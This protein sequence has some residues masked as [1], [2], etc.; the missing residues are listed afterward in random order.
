[1][2]ASVNHIFDVRLSIALWILAA[3]AHKNGNVATRKN[4]TMAETNPPYI[5]MTDGRFPW[6]IYK[7]IKKVDPLNIYIYIIQR[8]S[9]RSAF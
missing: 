8:S 9:E 6:P 2:T 3:A 1:M 7:S 5:F 4:R